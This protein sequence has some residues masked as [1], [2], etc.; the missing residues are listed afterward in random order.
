MSNSGG[1]RI[2]SA[3]TKPEKVARESHQP[4][5]VGE[6]P[7][8]FLS[9]EIQQTQSMNVMDGDHELVEMRYLSDK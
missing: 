5:A 6:R 9:K 3:R 1:T 8:N 2:V 7:A 4:R